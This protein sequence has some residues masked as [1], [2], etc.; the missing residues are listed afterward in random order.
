MPARLWRARRV[1]AAMEPKL[2]SVLLFD[3]AADIPHRV[4]TEAT[5]AGLAAARAHA[6][7]AVD[8]TGSLGSARE[9]TRRVRVELTLRADPKS[10]MA[11][12][13]AFGDAFVERLAARGLDAA[14]V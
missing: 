11:A 5:E 8:A 13:K 6:G 3:V 7:P 10:A 2:T 12:G 14:Q 1:A 4:L 9:G